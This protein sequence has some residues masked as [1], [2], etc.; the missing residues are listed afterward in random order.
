MVS[1]KYWSVCPVLLPVTIVTADPRLTY[2]CPQACTTG[3]PLRSSDG[4]PAQGKLTSTACVP[5]SRSS[6]QV[7]TPTSVVHCSSVNICMCV[8]YRRLSAV[9]PGGPSLDQAD[10]RVGPGPGYRFQCAPALL[11]PGQ[12]GPA[13]PPRGPHTQPAGL[14]LHTAPRHEGIDCSLGTQPT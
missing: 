6:I 10:C 4:D 14:A 13:A 7:A 12:G 8:F 3:P 11:R 9:G 2:P 5:S 1:N